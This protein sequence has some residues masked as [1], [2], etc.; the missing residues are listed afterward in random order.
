MNPAREQ[1]EHAIAVDGS[2]IAPDLRATL[3]THRLYGLP[4][5]RAVTIVGEVADALSDWPAVA[6]ETG[7]AES[8]QAIVGVAFSTIAS[9][10]EITGRG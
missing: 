4:E 7:I 9:P 8:E 3:A 5:D 6:S 1:R 10:F 2:T